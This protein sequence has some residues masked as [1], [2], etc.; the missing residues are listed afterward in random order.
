MATTTKRAAMRPINPDTV[1]VDSDVETWRNVTAGIVVIS[2]VG[3]YGR[4]FGESVQG[5]RT[6]QITPHE[7]RQHQMAC[8]LPDLDPF[9]NGTLQPIELIDGEPDSEV[10]RNNPNML[11][12]GDVPR[13][14]G[15]RGTTF[16]ERVGRITNTSVIERLL[17]EARGRSATVTLEQ[18]ETLRDR[19]KELHGQLADVTIGRDSDPNVPG[20]PKAVTP[21]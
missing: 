21:R 9:T 20:L 17:D 6:F 12:D 10:L 15:M 19:A 13:L 7:R 4:R 11:T 18:Y 16:A 2:R 14:F 1:P 3:E 5:G 8:A